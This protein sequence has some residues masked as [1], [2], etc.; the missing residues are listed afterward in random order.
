[1]QPA[2]YIEVEGVLAPIPE[3]ATVS[4]EG[5]VLSAGTDIGEVRVVAEISRMPI[6]EI[7]EM[8]YRVLD[9][10]VLTS[11]QVP[12]SMIKT[13][14]LPVGLGACSPPEDIIDHS[15]PKP[16]E[17]PA[18]PKPLMGVLEDEP[19]PPTKPV[20][21]QVSKQIKEDVDWGYL[22]ASEY[23]DALAKIAE[24][25]AAALSQYQEQVRG[26]A[27]AVH[28][29]R[30]RNAEVTALN[31]RLLSEYDEQVRLWKDRVSADN[32]AYALREEE[33]KARWTR[34]YAYWGR[35]IGALLGRMKDALPMGINGYPM[36]TAVQIL[37][38]DD[39]SVLADLCDKEIA[40]RN[41]DIEAEGGME[42]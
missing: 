26:Y 40:R 27:N 21:Q 13:L 31:A 20:L 37:H 6:R 33:Y 2:Y 22:D 9:G 41:S 34:V 14:F 3:G 23:Q 1:M 38:K 17:V 25:N 18:P 19:E 35:N 30:I 29:T 12:E 10:S 42:T 39:W 7:R 36:F 4:R 24:D 16:A 8:V 32:A 11:A 5:R 28:E 15:P